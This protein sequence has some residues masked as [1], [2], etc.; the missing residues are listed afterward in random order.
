VYCIARISLQSAHGSVPQ[1][2]VEVWFAGAM[3]FDNTHIFN[4]LDAPSQKL[5]YP[6]PLLWH[7]GVRYAQHGRE[8]HG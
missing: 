2:Y 3:T 8:R 1:H 6:V 4:L 7:F 5:Q